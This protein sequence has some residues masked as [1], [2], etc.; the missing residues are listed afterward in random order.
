MEGPVLAAKI[1]VHFSNEYDIKI[2][3]NKFLRV[4]R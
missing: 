1:K 2:K 3:D 4:Y